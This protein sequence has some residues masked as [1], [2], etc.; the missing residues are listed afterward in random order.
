MPLIPEKI[1]G[2]LN[3]LILF[4]STFLNLIKKIIF[5]WSKGL[6]NKRFLH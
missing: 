4:I 3:K 6:N 2:S 1:F 5:F